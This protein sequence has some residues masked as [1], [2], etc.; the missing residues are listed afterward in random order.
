MVMYFCIMPPPAFS[1]YPWTREPCRHTV[2]YYFS[3]SYG[4]GAF[5][6][7]ISIVQLKTKIYQVYFNR[8]NYLCFT[9]FWIWNQ[10]GIQH[11]QFSCKMP[12]DKP[13]RYMFQFPALSYEYVNHNVYPLS[14]LRTIVRRHINCFRIVVKQLKCDI[15]RGAK[16]SGVFF[17]CARL[18]MM[19]LA[20]T[21]R[22]L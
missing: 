19:C 12:V 7:I 5:K 1:P 15:C 8:V 9:Q 11:N 3:F 4:C 20:P 2:L 17:K 21:E 22:P 16:D 13:S 6:F 14:A 18:A 10:Q